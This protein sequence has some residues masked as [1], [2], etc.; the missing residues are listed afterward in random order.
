MLYVIIIRFWLIDWFFLIIQMKFKTLVLKFN[1]LDNKL[2]S[3]KS[4]A[5]HDHSMHQ[6]FSGKK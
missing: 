3:E 2:L 6:G 1:G 5:I 4:G